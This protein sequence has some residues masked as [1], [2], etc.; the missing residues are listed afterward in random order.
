MVMFDH[1][2][3]R[4]N[5]ND[6]DR[7]PGETS[8]DPVL[9]PYSTAE[10]DREAE[11]RL[12]DLLETTAKPL[13]YSIVGR[14]YNVSLRDPRYNT[15]DYQDALDTTSRVIFV[16]IEELRKF[17]NAPSSHPIESFLG[18]V[19][20][21]TYH[22]YADHMRVDNKARVSFVRKLRR[23]FD[24]PGNDYAVWQPDKGR[25]ICGLLKWRES[26][27]F[28]WNEITAQ[29]II[30]SV[31]TVV[32]DKRQSNL[33][34]LTATVF[35]VAQQPV[36]FDEFVE[37]VGRLTGEFVKQ[38]AYVVDDRSD[39]ATTRLQARMVHPVEWIYARTYLAYQYHEVCQLPW[40]QY[41]AFML[42]LINAPDY[43][44][45]KFTEAFRVTTEQEIAERL[46]MDTDKFARLLNTDE[47]PSYV[48]VA[49]YLGEKSLDYAGLS[50]D[51]AYNLCKV[52]RGRIDERMKRFEN[53]FKRVE[54]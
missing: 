54:K 9:R 41:A 29:Q 13:I 31:E 7:L 26:N 5:R 33:D 28:R 34:A 6:P 39:D 17:K 37:A 3:R 11:Q 25:L 38:D 47:T 46:K 44:I 2:R 18:L 24:D 22:A 52:A 15:T 53:G 51:R 35:G 4:A 12:V 32:I 21:L 43:G 49:Q 14:K 45:E 27:G 20:T 1:F 16:L 19:A 50:A 48:W 30:E 42:R 23:F 10:T 36:V 8:V 40:G